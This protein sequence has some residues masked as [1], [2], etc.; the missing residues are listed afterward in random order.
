MAWLFISYGELYTHLI[1]SRKFS[2]F[3]SHKL[4]VANCVI[5]FVLQTVLLVLFLE[6]F[7]F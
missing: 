7:V 2:Q 5:S 4:K 6:V 3:Q 1:E